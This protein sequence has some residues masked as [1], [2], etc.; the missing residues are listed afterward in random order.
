MI[1]EFFRGCLLDAAGM[2][3]YASGDSAQAAHSARHASPKMPEASAT[4]SL[5]TI[6]GDVLKRQVAAVQ[7]Y[8]LLTVQAMRCLF[9]PPY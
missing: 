7:D 9:S 5:P 3:R 8:T 6:L 4:S 2:S 1:V